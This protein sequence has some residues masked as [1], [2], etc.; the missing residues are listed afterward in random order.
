MDSSLITWLT[1]YAHLTK[2]IRGEEG[3]K[4]KDSNVSDSDC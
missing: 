4:R 2:I 1:N 3:G